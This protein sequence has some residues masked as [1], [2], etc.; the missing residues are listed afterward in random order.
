MMSCRRFMLVVLVPFFIV[1]C[2]K[3]EPP[4][5]QKPPESAD[6]SRVHGGSILNAVA[7][8][9]WSIPSNWNVLPPR[10]MRV[11]TYGV[12]IVGAENEPTECGIFY[13]GA[14]A[15]GSVDANIERW[16]GQFETSSKP[17]RA[18]KEVNG[19]PVTV[20]QIAGAYLSPGGPMMQSQGKKEDFRLLGAIVSGPEG[21]VFFKLTGPSKSVAA[22]EKDFTAMINSLAKM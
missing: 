1:A 16:E 13:F 22:V 18:S 12:P 20:V 4:Q 19:L 5:P 2:T 21:P 6:L 15:G 7:G 11:A 14:D 9:K 17:S 8:L 10:Q 3:K